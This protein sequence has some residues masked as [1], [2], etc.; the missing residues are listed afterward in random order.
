MNDIEMQEVEEANLNKDSESRIANPVAE[1][2]CDS[3]NAKDDEIGWGSMIFK[4]LKA[5]IFG[6]C[7]FFYDMTSKS[8]IKLYISHCL[9]K[10][11]SNKQISYL[12]MNTHII[13]S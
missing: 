9:C 7:V 4:F 10:F 2:K 11:I 8:L 13:S 12:L 6:L 5:L 1:A 3:N